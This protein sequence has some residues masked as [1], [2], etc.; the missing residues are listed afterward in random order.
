[1][2][3]EFKI[4][5]REAGLLERVA[6]ATKMDYWFSITDDLKAIDVYDDFDTPEQAVCALED[7][8]GYGLTEPQS[9]GLSEEEAKEVKAVFRRARYAC[10]DWR[11]FS[12][13]VYIEGSANEL[14]TYTIEGIFEEGV[15]ID[16]EDAP[17]DFVMLRILHHSVEPCFPSSLTSA[18]QGV[19]NFF[20]TAMLVKSW[21]PEEILKAINEGKRLMVSYDYDAETN[22]GVG[23]DCRLFP[24][25]SAA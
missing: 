15:F 23:P 11:K 25:W 14:P 19:I 16:L 2:K 21:L 3:K 13:L 5:E 6:E 17:N 1:M 20:G 18:K 7:G 4:T 9:G 22:G 24:V 8:L 10:C 12:A